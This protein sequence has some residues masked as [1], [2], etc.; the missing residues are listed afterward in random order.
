MKEEILLKAEKLIN[1]YKEGLLGGH[2]MPEDSNPGLPKTSLENYLYF[3]LPMA[4]NYQR[5]SYT[6]WESALKTYNDEETKFLFNPKEVINKPESEVQKALIKYRLALQKDKQTKIWITLCHT[7]VNLFDGDIRK[8]FDQNENDP[9]KIRE[10][11]QI[12]HKKE[13]PYLSGNKL[14]NYWMYVIYEYTG[15]TYTDLSKLTVAPDIHVCRATC[16]LGLITEEELNSSK[17]QELVIQRWHELMKNS[18][19]NEIDVHTP[20]W[21]WARNNFIE[22]R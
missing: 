10:F 11:M 5:N 18:K 22:I 7:F 3:T 8:I 9:D 20:L 14:C 4:L 1:M 13:F 6:L 17:V 12:K 16:K 2:V 21:L 19:Y 15:R